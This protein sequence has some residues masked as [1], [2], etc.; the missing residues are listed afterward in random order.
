MQ[1]F[2]DVR[3]FTPNGSLADADHLAIF[4]RYSGRM[5]ALPQQDI[6]GIWLDVVLA[7][8]AVLQEV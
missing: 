5:S 3:F 4:V 1:S 6:A 2:E 7:A 8:E